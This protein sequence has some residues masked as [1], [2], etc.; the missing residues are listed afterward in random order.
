[1]NLNLIQFNLLFIKKNNAYVNMNVVYFE[2]N[3]L[4]HNHRNGLIYISTFVEIKNNNILFN[5][6]NYCF[7]DI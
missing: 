6:R 7:F 1:M 5:L 4:W 2:I 3:M